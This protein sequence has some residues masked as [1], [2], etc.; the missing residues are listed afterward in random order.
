M[1]SDKNKSILAFHITKPQLKTTTGPASDNV[2]PDVQRIVSH[3]GTVRVR[4]QAF[5]LLTYPA[6]FQKQVDIISVPI[7]GYNQSSGE[8]LTHNGQPLQE[9]SAE[10]GPLRIR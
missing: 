7:T 3:I 5:T 6:A 1:V 10:E 8:F 2:L 4:S 9:L